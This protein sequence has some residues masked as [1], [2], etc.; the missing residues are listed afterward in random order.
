MERKI[1]RIADV[2]VAFGVSEERV[3]EAIRYLRCEGISDDEICTAVNENFWFLD[4]V[5]KQSFFNALLDVCRRY[6][7]HLP[8]M[9]NRN[10][11]SGNPVRDRL[12]EVGKYDPSSP[13]Y[14]GNIIEAHKE[15]RE[16]R[17]K[18]RFRAWGD[19]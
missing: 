8:R 1:K 16:R 11:P 4:K 6:A 3:D 10:K 9:A 15:R 13:Y 19:I 18:L 17:K 12:L 2:A 7:R 14:V 5:A